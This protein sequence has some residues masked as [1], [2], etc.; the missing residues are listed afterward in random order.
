[1]MEHELFAIHLKLRGVKVGVVPAIAL[2]HRPLVDK[3]H[4]EFAAYEQRRHA[5]PGAV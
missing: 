4:P 5:E 2:A 3:H 1:M